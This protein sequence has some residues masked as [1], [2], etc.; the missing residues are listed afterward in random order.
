MVPEEYPLIVFDS[1]SD[2]CIYNNGEYT[3]NT[4]HIASRM[5]FLSNE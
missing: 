1:K 4:R 3:K 2:M 5:D